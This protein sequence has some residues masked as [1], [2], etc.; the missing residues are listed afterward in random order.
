MLRLRERIDRPGWSWFYQD[1]DAMAAMYVMALHH[2]MR[3]WGP[4][5]L[6]ARLAAPLAER[7]RFI[8]TVGGLAMAKLLF[9]GG[10]RVGFSLSGGDLDLHFTS[11][12]DEPL[13]LALPRRTHCNGDSRIAAV[14]T[15]C[16]AR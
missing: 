10:N 7:D 14:P 11:A 4:H 12:A 13:S 3:C 15:C 2:L 6:L 1:D 9:D 16:A 5:P 8:R